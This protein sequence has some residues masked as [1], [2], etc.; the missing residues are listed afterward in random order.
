MFGGGKLRFI[1]I[2]I[3]SKGGVKDFK[4]KNLRSG[5]HL[6]FFSHLHAKEKKKTRVGLRPFLRDMLPENRAV[7]GNAQEPSETLTAGRK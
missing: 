3:L 5:I 1:F 6:I 7:C 4:K 2:F